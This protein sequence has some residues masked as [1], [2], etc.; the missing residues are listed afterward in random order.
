MNKSSGSVH[1]SHSTFSNAHSL[2]TN[3]NNKETIDSICSSIHTKKIR[4]G[5]KPNNQIINQFSSNNIEL[6][7]LDNLFENYFKIGYNFL[8]LSITNSNY[9]KICKNYLENFKKNIADLN[10]LN[11]PLP[12]KSDLNY[13]NTNQSL[14]NKLIGITS[15]WI[16][17]DSED[18]LINEFSLQVITNEINYCTFLGIED[19]LISPP[20]S[21]NNLLIY[22]NNLNSLLLKFPTIKFSI[23]LPICETNILKN[24]LSNLNDTV[25]LN[26]TYSVNTLTNNGENINKNDNIDYLSTWEI[27]NKI[28]ISCNYN[29]NLYIS[30]ASPNS[31]ESELPEYLIDRWCIEP[32]KFYLI[33]SSRFIPNQKKFP[34]LSKSNQLVFWK[35]IQKNALSPPSIVLHGTEIEFKE[36]ISIADNS[37]N[38]NIQTQTYST[39]KHNNTNPNR[40]SMISNNS[41]SSSPSSSS[42]FVSFAPPSIHQNTNNAQNLIPQNNS[43]NN[44][45]SF[46]SP[47][48]PSRSINSNSL[49][50]SSCVN[51]SVNNK[52]YNLGDLSYFEYIKYLIKSS[53]SNNQLLP[54]ENYNINSLLSNKLSEG[55]LQVP[56]QPLNNNLTNLTYQLFEHDSTKYDC[57]ERAIFQAISDLIEIP[58]FKQVKYYNETTKFD[59]KNSLNILVVGPG[60]G[61]LIDKV[62]GCLKV[63]NLNLSRVNIIAIEKNPNVII[64]LNEKNTNQWMNKVKILY[65][66]IRNWNGLI[67]NL[68]F[69]DNIINGLLNNNKFHLIIS[70]LLGSFGCNELS[71]EC[72][73]STTKFTDFKNCIFIPQSYSSYIAPVISPK[74]YK[75]ISSFND[76]SKFHNMYIP[77]YDQFEI[78][79]SEA[80][81]V[82]QFNHNSEIYQDFRSKISNRPAGNLNFRNKRISKINLT[83]KNKG[84]IHGLIG[85]FE[86]TLYLDIKI[87]NSPINPNPNSLI[88]WLPIFLPIEQPINVVNNQEISILLKRDTDN[89]K[90]WY[91]WSIETFN[92]IIIPNT[93]SLLREL[94]SIN[95]SMFEGDFTDYDDNNDTLQLRVS[96]NISKIHNAFGKTFSLKIQ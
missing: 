44:S 86:S 34:V 17:L 89:S 45:F 8:I 80:K 46:S 1:S 41:E 95:T 62:L 20:N 13:C 36:L 30:L 40:V 77:I 58:R 64:H 49:P 61:P 43:S 6:S 79:S 51:I 93:K 55:T 7:S 14:T 87:S 22:S 72:I 31:F 76:F 81:K 90:V 74:L 71:P 96:S 92:F 10:F 57:Y 11:V 26:N 85:Y 12:N 54:I 18:P 68:N 63:L 32:L 70:E 88:S 4:I 59:H 75:K 28:R 56:L 27:W 42:S 16:E 37:N 65:Q 83:C 35:I 23:P 39:I 33:S 15:S 82:W 67:T 29:K 19:I 50:Q 60:R 84:T 2:N 24:N 73:D 66:D 9:R 91:E 3:G 94:S 5:I 47:N 53:Y 38:T 21:L 48:S 78:L 25:N 52:V 69:S